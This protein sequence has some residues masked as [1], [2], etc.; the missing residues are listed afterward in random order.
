MTPFQLEPVP[1]F[2]TPSRNTTSFQGRVS[3]GS[4]KTTRRKQHVNPRRSSVLATSNRGVQYQK[5]VVITLHRGVMF[6]WHAINIYK[7]YHF[8]FYHSLYYYAL[9]MLFLY[10]L[11]NYHHHFHYYYYYYYSHS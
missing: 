6:G 8:H 2:L 10:L 11:L 5:L 4:S 9:G 1:E 3:T 7:V